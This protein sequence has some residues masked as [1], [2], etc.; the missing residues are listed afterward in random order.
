MGMNVQNVQEISI[1]PMKNVIRPS[2]LSK[3]VGYTKVAENS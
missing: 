3:I 1:K 2:A